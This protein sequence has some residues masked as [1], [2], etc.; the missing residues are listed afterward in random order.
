MS[1][2][3]RTKLDGLSNYDD[4]AISNSLSNKVDK[5][6]G[7]ELSENNYTDTDKDKLDGLSN[8]DDSNVLKDSD[9]V[10]PVTD[11]NKILTQSEASSG[12]AVEV[13]VETITADKTLT[14]TDEVYHAITAD[15]TGLKINMYAAGVDTRNIIS[16]QGSNAFDVIIEEAIA[17]DGYVVSGSGEADV[18]G[19]YVNDGTYN[20][21]PRWKNEN[22]IYLVCSDDGEWQFDT[23]S[24]PVDPGTS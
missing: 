1:S 14:L 13:N 8:Y 2:E 5:V 4:T 15:A 9:T 18:N 17:G 20:S 21:K 11:T 3:D 12:S 16:N 22:N 10:S 24:T 23:S 19:T 6:A 7:K